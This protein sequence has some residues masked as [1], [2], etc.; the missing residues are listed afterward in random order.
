MAQSQPPKHGGVEF[1][2]PLRATR[3][4]TEAPATGIATEGGPSRFKTP[5]TSEALRGNTSPG[6]HKLHVLEKERN[7]HN[8]PFEQI[9]LEVARIMFGEDHLTDLNL[10]L[11]HIALEHYQIPEIMDCPNANMG[12]NGS[13]AEHKEPFEQ[14]A[15]N[16]ARILFGDDHLT[17][18]NIRLVRIALEHYNV[19]EI[20]KTTG[21]GEPTGQRADNDGC[22]VMQEAGATV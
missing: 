18:L 3:P 11:A 8:Q 16:V 13:E 22:T 6:N 4:V 20:F 14:T 17:D 7:E 1:T 9:V 5:K 12:G 10:R 15:F 21:G 2:W 19:R